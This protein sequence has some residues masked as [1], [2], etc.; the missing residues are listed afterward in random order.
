MNIYQ[1]RTIEERLK[2]AEMLRQDIDLANARLFIDTMDNI[3]NESYAALPERLF[4]LYEG[5]LSYIGGVGPMF[6][7]LAEVE[8]WLQSFETEVK[9]LPTKMLKRSAHTNQVTPFRED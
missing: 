7:N 1:H 5:K 9:R 8:K 3:A 4:I 6:Y 2:A